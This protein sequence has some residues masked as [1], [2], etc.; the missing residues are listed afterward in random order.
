MQKRTVS[1]T[2]TELAVSEPE[3][4]ACDI[5]TQAQGTE[6]CEPRILFGRVLA[7][8]GPLIG[9]GRSEE[10]TIKARGGKDAVHALDE[11]ALLTVIERAINGR[12][13]WTQG[14]LEGYDGGN[15]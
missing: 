4:G 2:R 14:W 11:G 9:D 8:I 10:L 12:K 15:S 5:G 1:Q 7:Q 13:C 6:A 3:Q